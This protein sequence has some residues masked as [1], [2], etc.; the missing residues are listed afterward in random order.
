[1]CLAAFDMC[2]M[3]YS[4]HLVWSHTVFHLLLSCSITLFYGVGGRK[5]I[6]SLIALLLIHFIYFGEDLLCEMMNEKFIA[7][8]IYFWQWVF[9]HMHPVWQH[10]RLRKRDLKLTFVPQKIRVVH[11]R[12]GSVL[13]SE[14]KWK[15]IFWNRMWKLILQNK[16]ASWN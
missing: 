6:S 10:E 12:N 11:F 9:L 16:L 1:M 4:S 3:L 5:L 7:K 14:A 13:W 8:L 15:A 2:V